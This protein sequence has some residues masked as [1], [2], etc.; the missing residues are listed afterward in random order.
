MTRKDRFYGLHKI[1]QNVQCLTIGSQIFDKRNLAR[2]QIIT[3]DQ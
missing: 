2:R 1:A 3:D